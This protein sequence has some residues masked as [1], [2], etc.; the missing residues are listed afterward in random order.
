MTAYQTLLRLL[1]ASFR[2]EYGEE[3]RAVFAAR[4][5]DAAGAPAVVALWIEAI[6]VRTSG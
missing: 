3:M 6:A 1:P 5:R 4:R 2:A